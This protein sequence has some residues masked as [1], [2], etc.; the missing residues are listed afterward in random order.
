MYPLNLQEKYYNSTL[1]R[2]I[3]FTYTFV[4]QRYESGTVEKE[5][6]KRD[7]D[8]YIALLNKRISTTSVSLLLRQSRSQAT[9]RK[10]FFLISQGR[11]DE[12]SMC[13]LPDH[14]T[15]QRV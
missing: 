10:L 11:V 6:N 4:A 1:S 3:L 9:E 7:K 15:D 14:F 8:E 2:S 5:K 13:C 12:T